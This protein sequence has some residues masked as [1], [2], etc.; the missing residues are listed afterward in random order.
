MVGFVRRISSVS[1]WMSLSS[2]SSDDGDERMQ[3]NAVGKR[4]QALECGR[5][6]SSMAHAHRTRPLGMDNVLAALPSPIL[7]VL[8]FL[9]LIWTATPSDILC[10]RST[11]VLTS[12]IKSPMSPGAPALVWIKR[13][14]SINGSRAV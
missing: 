6:P 7:V 2:P 12:T 9:E 14:S 8:P 4:A 3:L 10:S 13:R 1:A 11:L 5:L